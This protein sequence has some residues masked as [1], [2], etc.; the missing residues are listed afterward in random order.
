ML[1]QKSPL[2]ARLSGFELSRGTWLETENDCPT[3]S[4]PAVFGVNV[5]R[6]GGQVKPEG[7]SLSQPLQGQIDPL[8]QAFAVN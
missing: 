6:R 2:L 5:A 8:D 1:G 7:L 4:L 3:L